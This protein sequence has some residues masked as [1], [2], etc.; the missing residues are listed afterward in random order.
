LTTPLLC[1]I[2]IPTKY[3]REVNKMTLF[4]IVGVVGGAIW[5]NLDMHDE[6]NH[7]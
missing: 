1:D 5:Y 7:R 3:I 6:W 2:I 4:I